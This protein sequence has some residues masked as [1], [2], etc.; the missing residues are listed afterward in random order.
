MHIFPASDKDLQ[1]P[2]RL[3]HKADKEFE[4][5]PALLANT[6]IQAI[7]DNS[8]SWILGSKLWNNFLAS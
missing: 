7:Q 1:R 3:L 2:L 8:S 6:L 5:Q 4:N